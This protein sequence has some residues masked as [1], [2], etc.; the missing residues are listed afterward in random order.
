MLQTKL[1]KTSQH[2]ILFVVL[3]IVGLIIIIGST[4]AVAQTDI[5]FQTFR[6]S[7]SQFVAHLGGSDLIV[8]VEHTQL[9]ADGRSQSKI[10]ITPINISSP[11][12]ANI[13]QGGGQIELLASEDDDILFVYTAGSDPGE[14]V[15]VFAAGV[16]KQIVKIELI[17][18]ETPAVPTITSPP[19][20]T[21]INNS[22]PEI[23][24]TGSANTKIIITSNGKANTITRTD[25]HGRFQT[26]LDKPLYNGQHTLAAIAVN[27]L[28]V[29]SDISNLVTITVKTNPAGIDKTNIRVIPSRAIVGESFAIF[30]PTSLNAAK[31][32]IEIAGQIYEL[33]DFNK[34]SVFTAV[35][36]APIEPGIYI[37]DII[38]VDISGNINRFDQSI[39]VTVI[40]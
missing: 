37:G 14:S 18:S 8:K 7:I 15:V 17:R 40:S 29:Q 33:F 38:V 35:L 36:P 16:L 22:K 3:G 23:V 31:V 9:P 30:V 28:G 32:T 24:G 11:F 1:S 20:K 12:T 2:K 13:I 34:T 25:E 19:D 6:D 39:S 21:Q 5:T 27:E 10:W 26:H 4:V